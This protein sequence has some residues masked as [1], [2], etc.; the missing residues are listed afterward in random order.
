[1]DPKVVFFI[2]IIVMALPRFVSFAKAQV[3][4][5]R[6]VFSNIGSP[7]RILDLGLAFNSD[8]IVYAAAAGLSLI[9]GSPDTSSRVSCLTNT[10]LPSYNPSM[11]LMIQG[12]L[13]RQEVMLEYF[14]SDT[15][16][17]IIAVTRESAGIYS[18]I[19]GPD[20]WNQEN[21]LLSN[22]RHAE[23]ADYR[24][25]SEAISK[26]LLG[27]VALKIKGKARAIIIAHNELAGFPFEILTL[28]KGCSRLPL[29]PPC[30]FVEGSEI[31]YNNSVFQWLSSRIG[32]KSA[33]KEKSVENEL[34]FVGFSSGFEYHECVQVLENAERE[35]NTI[36][37]MFRE[38]GKHPVL[39]IDENS[40]KS[41]FK[42]IARF[43]H[44]LHFAT[45]ALSS[46]KFPE[47]NGL[48]FHESGSD[49][50]ADPDDG[51]L[52]IHEIC[53]LQIPAD[54]IVLNA[55][56]TANIR[57]RV[58][59]RWVSCADCFIQAGAKNVLCTLWNVNDRLAESFM[60][61]FYTYYLEGMTY[62]KALQKV[63]IHMIHQQSTS[64]PVNWAAYV[65]IGE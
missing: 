2:F 52:A 35:I 34:S 21:I 28:P 22:I 60:V 8:P 65:L 20:F 47:L 29:R 1:M 9:P 33:G 44:I 49:D 40:N 24:I 14:P 55:C 11:I 59:M 6:E 17:Y 30:Y 13:S 16:T 3:L 58:G 61:E 45:H 46:D 37:N 4:D 32:S 36:G 63:K 27:A 18:L 25:Q 53:E 42:S 31:V 43:S 50:N 10:E 57:S 51:L 15:L 41:N 5:L 64:L 23:L 39:L 26:I 12:L 54:L 19:T 62:S 48:L 56:A 7:N 38:K